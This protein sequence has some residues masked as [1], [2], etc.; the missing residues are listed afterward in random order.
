[1]IGYKNVRWLVVL[2]ILGG[3]ASQP[4]NIAAADVSPTQYRDYNCKQIELEAGALS[5]REAALHEKL[6]KTAETDAKQ[7]AI[8]LLFFP[9]TLLWLEGGDGAEAELYA[10]TKGS[11]EA[12]TTAAAEKN[13]PAPKFSMASNPS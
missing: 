7:L 10:R 4:E 1:M 6:G 5:R 9:P 3:C 13:C 11:R 8:G 12:L 2:V